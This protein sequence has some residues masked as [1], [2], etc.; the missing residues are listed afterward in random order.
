M[1]KLQFIN[2][3]AFVHLGVVKKPDT[4]VQLADFFLK[5]AE[6]TWSIASGISG[7]QLIIII[8]NA[9]FR[10]HAGK[11]ASKLFGHVGSAGGHK[12]SARA[13]IPLRNI[14]CESASDEDCRK[15]IINRIKTVSG[16][17]N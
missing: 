2:H 17:T 14:D 3:I 5:L 16:I 4:L 7:Q 15:Y 8:R 6:A 12:D 13:E 11:M 1:Q 9:G 10:R